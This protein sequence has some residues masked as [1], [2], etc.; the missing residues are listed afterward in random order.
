MKKLAIA[1]VLAYSLGVSA[2][3]NTFIGDFTMERSSVST[4]E[5]ENG[6]SVVRDN[7][8]FARGSKTYATSFT[9]ENDVKIRE[10]R[11]DMNAL[12]IDGQFS[13]YNNVLYF[14]SKG[15]L[16]SSELKNGLWS[17]PKELKIDGLGVS[18]DIRE[19]G[20]GT[21]LFYGRWLYRTPGKSKEPMYNPVVA[22][23]GNRLYF[24]S[25]MKGGMG[26]MDIWYIEKNTSG[27]SWSAP[28][29]LSAVNSDKNEDY[30]F[31][32]NDNLLYFSSDRA[33]KYKGYNIY[34]KSLTDSSAPLLM[35]AL[36]NSDFDDYNFV[37]AGGIPMY[38]ST[39]KGN[40]DIYY[41][42]QKHEEED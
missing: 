15:I 26:G 13:E 9:N 22:N 20:P 39:K 36:Y 12:E 34:K 29:N 41:A 3:D 18:R 37:V 42:K 38:I 23:K 19:A 30:P 5:K 2:F 8:Y 27:D 4:N 32:E 17:S 40:A 14:S 21:S 25:E 33:A 11:T 16:Y 10:E 7:L 31:V 28:V 24:S 35:D 6:L 1:V